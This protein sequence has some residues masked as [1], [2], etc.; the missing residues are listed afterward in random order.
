MRACTVMQTA[1]AREA[2]D[3]ICKA[4]LSGQ[5]EEAIALARTLHANHDRRNCAPPQSPRVRAWFDGSCWPNPGGYAGCGA[6]VKR[7]DRIIFSASEYL[8]HGPHLSNNVAEYAGIIAVLRFLLRERV[9]WATVYGDSQMVIKQLLGAQ[10]AS[11][12]LYLPYY[13]TA[14]DLLDKL[15]GVRLKWISRGN[16]GEADALSRKCLPE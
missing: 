6:I 9:Q 12:G 2:L 11:R 8:G 1:R 5:I 13:E 10:R 4:L 3:R 7:D 15:P 16:N 14:R